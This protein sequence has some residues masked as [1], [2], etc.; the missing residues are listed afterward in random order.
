MAQGRRD[1]VG[2]HG[3]NLPAYKPGI[4]KETFNYIRGF[5]PS[6]PL[7]NIHSS[8]FAWILAKEQ[9]PQ[10]VAS[11]ML[12]NLTNYYVILFSINILLLIVG[13]FMETVTAVNILVPV[14]IPLIASLGIDPV[15]F[16]VMMILNLMI[17]ILTPPFGTV[18]FVLSSVA[19]VPVERVAKNTA[20]FILP[21]LSG[22]DFDN[23]FPSINSISTQL[24]FWKI[25]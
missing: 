2:G 10:I 1:L 4:K 16:D 3:V 14:F 18:L 22:F 6:N 11:F 25:I 21:L 15:H 17:G 12:N 23:Y 7:K 20:L 24:N 9:V 13:C 8:L 5:Y 19:N